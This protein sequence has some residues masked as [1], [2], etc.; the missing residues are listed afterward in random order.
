MV[1]G[2]EEVAYL[3]ITS[4]GYTQPVIRWCCLLSPMSARS[5]W[6]VRKFLLREGIPNFFPPSYHVC[7]MF[8]LSPVVEYAQL[9]SRRQSEGARIWEIIELAECTDP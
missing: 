7:V 6:S 4:S 9:D 3:G 2:I 5:T 8:A 1:L